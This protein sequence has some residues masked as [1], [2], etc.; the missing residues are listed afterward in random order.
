MLTYSSDGCGDLIGQAPATAAAPQIVGQPVDQLVSA[1]DFV[2][3]S[4]VVAVTNGVTFQW[5]FNGTDIPAATGDSLLLAAAAAANVGQYT[6]RVT[7]SAGTVTSSSATLRL[8]SG[9]STPSSQLSL[10]AYSDPGGSVTV[11]PWQRYYAQGDTVTLTATPSAPSVFIGWH[12]DTTAEL[13]TTTNPTT[14]TMTADTTVRARFASPV[15]LAQ[16]M[17][18]FWRGETDATD[19]I[20]GHSGT[21]YTATTPTTASMTPK[22]KVGGAF[23][24]DGAVYVQVPNSA[25]LK[26]V[27]MTAEAWVSPGVSTGYNA[28]IA[29]GSSTDT[30][31]TWYLGVT[32][33]TPQF[34]SHGTD[35]LEAPSA[36]P[37]NQWTHLAITFDGNTK[38]LYV[39]GAQVASK[40]GLGE[41]DY[42]APVPVTIGADWTANAPTDVF[43]G[44]VDEV[45][46]YNRALTCDE[47]FDIYNA[48]VAGK[49]V[50]APY[51]TSTT[52]PPFGPATGFSSPGSF[53]RMTSYNQQ[54]TTVLGNAPVTFALSAGALPPGLTL[55]PAG[56]LLGDSRALGV[57]DFTVTATD[58]SGHSTDQ[59]YVLVV[60]PP[61]APLRLGP[62]ITTAPILATGFVGQAYTQTFTCLR[63]RA[64]VSYALAAGSVTPPGLTLTSAG[65]LSGTPTAAGGFAFTVVATDAEARFDEQ[66]CTLQAY[67]SVPAPAGMVGWWKAEGN[68]HDSAGTNNGALSPSGAGYA[69]G[70]VGQAFKLDGSKGY[71]EIPDAPALESA[72]LTVE[73]WVQCDSTLGLPTIFAKPVGS[74]SNNSYALWLNNFGTLTG[75]IATATTAGE[76]LSSS[77]GPLTTGTWYH[78]AYTVDDSAQKQVLYVDG[79]QVASAATTASASY[80][81]QPMF[82]GRGTLNAQPAFLLQGL[83]DEASIY[84]RALAPAEI[85]SIYNAGAAGKHL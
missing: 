24:F 12:E 72:S 49:N 83:I 11:T 16:G 56:V 6:V 23:N 37:F 32:S 51:F 39:N 19:L 44:L 74:G 27:Q 46:L 43:T 22:G 47:I 84:N 48:D 36:I 75:Q 9:A 63:G 79:V 52:S 65:V 2:S 29:C 69:A 53:P 18:A 31:D 45:S 66:P 54:L 78:V 59:L 82:L 34:Y 70:E 64:P 10:T 76:Q 85:A 15:P 80:D 67:E 20:G 4:V 26:P 1:G 21:F 28:V 73:A 30:D 60:E 50:T 17:V 40:G 8:D 25:A 68:A 7:N 61:V 57:Y 13:I 3:F 33:G 62:Q 77:A 81:N 38:V 71:V 35:L 5:A 55:S 14:V 41:L 58:A 42:P